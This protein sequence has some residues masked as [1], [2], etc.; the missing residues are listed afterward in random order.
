MNEHRSFLN[1]FV[2]KHLLFN[3]NAGWRQYEYYVRFLF[4][5]GFNRR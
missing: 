1:R 3:T 5:E 2:A 4:F